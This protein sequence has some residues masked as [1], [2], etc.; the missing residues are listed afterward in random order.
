MLSV[1]QQENSS[2]MA[3]ETYDSIK[4]MFNSYEYMVNGDLCTINKCV[5]AVCVY[6]YAILWPVIIIMTFI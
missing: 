5:H 2:I 4:H 1:N 6:N 3:E